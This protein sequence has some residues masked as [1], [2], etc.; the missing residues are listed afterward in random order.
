MQT[1]YDPQHIEAHWAKE[2]EEQGYFAPS[3]S[4]DLYYS[5]ALP[6]PNVTGSLHMGH[7]F[8]HSL[9][10]AL[11]RRARMQGKNTLWQPG[12]DHAGI[13]TQMVVERQ[14]SA[15]ST[16]RHDLGRDAF[17]ERVWKWREQS[18]STI[19]QQ[20]R[21]LGTSLDWSRLRFSMDDEMTL[22]TYTAFI[23][24]YEDGL[25]YRGQRLVNWDTAF[26]SAISD[27]EV[28]NKAQKGH[29]WHI[30]YPLSDG[31]S[32]LTVATTRPETLFGDAAVAVHPDDERYTKLIGKTIRLPLTTRDIPIIADEYVDREFGSGCVKITPAHD[33]NDHEVGKRHKLTLHSIMEY[34][35]KLNNTVPKEYVGMDR[36]AAR[37]KVVADLDAAGLLEKVE[38]H[39]HNVPYGD[40][41]GTV[42]E[43]MLTDQWFLKADV[44]AQPAI[45]AVHNNSL[46]FIPENWS[47]TYLQW[48]ENIQ[49]W[50]IS[51]QL[52]WG[53][54]I[55]VWYGPAGQIY[56]GL[57]EADARKRH[58]LSDDIIL[59]QDNDVFDTWF[60][61]ALWPFATL[62][63]PHNTEMLKHF[64]PT[65]VLV[66]GFDIIFFWVARMVMMG[67]YFMQDVPFHEVYVTGL[68]R[69]AEGQKMSKSKGNILDPIDLID[70]ITLEALVEKRTHNLMQPKLAEKIKKSTQKEFPQGIAA[71]GTDAL[72][73][74]FCAL[75][76]T[77]RDINFDLG[78]IE[79]YRNFCNKLWNAARFVLMN[80]EH[81][82]HTEERCFSLADQWIM[83]A[84]QTTIDK[85]NLA[86]ERYRF[87]LVAQALYEFTWNHYCDWYLELA[88]CVL[89][90]TDTTPAQ[91]NAAQHTLLTVFEELLRLMHP[92]MPFISEEIWQTI[93]TR[94]EVNRQKSIMLEPYPQFNSQHMHPTAVIEMNWL[95]QFIALIRTL[96]SEIGVSPAKEVM[97]LINGATEHDKKRLQHGM[98]YLKSLAKIN[99]IRF[100]H[101]SDEP[102][103]S[104]SAVLDHLDIHIPLAGLIDK[105]AELSRLNKEIIKLQQE[106]EKS[107][108]KLNNTNYTDKAPAEVVAKE[109]ER[110]AQTAQALEKLQSYYDKCSR[111]L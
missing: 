95:Q 84:L 104:A 27:L 49:D 44:L 85:V 105:T 23:K 45:D 46:K 30:R 57:N 64:Y 72:R 93:A 108:N 29:L 43:P 65:Q 7:G 111:H 79:G 77:G 97:L 62:G 63:W 73:F 47:K 102:P 80:T 16:S 74:T 75:A 88:K 33:F 11:I 98:V 92:I 103:L 53:H 76:T 37:T 68:V 81:Y 48:L 3:M 38:E 86:F 66:T 87:D 71:H 91:K 94:L 12:T 39:T 15:E 96:R 90:S 35:G 110:L 28:E 69:D 26:Q 13:A 21:R 61:S 14:L 83:S 58:H 41:S 54:R 36:F 31:S 55:P 101:T 25:I 18:G 99:A 51:R 1:Q 20:M 60:T 24:L 100:M 5:I 56:V 4:S 42:I 40:R 17:I 59:R 19:T 70:G 82:T 50:C 2:W 67:L 6:P 9:M 107:E 89:Y 52:W 32:Y 10:D 34:D 8:Q 106:Q 78:R 22:A 109:R